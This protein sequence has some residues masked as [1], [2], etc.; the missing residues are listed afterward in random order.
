MPM[1]IG[2]LAVKEAVASPMGEFVT[3]SFILPE[4]LKLPFTV[5]VCG[6]AESVTKVACGTVLKYC[7]D[8]VGG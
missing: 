6:E 2:G 4:T 3:A 8:E 7:V 5:T 1:V